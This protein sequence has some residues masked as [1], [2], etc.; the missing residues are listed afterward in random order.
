MED[1]IRFTS[2]ALEN[3]KSVKMLGLS[4]RMSAMIGGLRYAEVAASTVFRK[5]VIGSVVLCMSP[6]RI[7]MLETP[8]ENA[9]KTPLSEQRI[10]LPIWRRWRL[11]RSM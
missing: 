11:S 3:I 8:Q 9:D 6:N 10:H 2:Y 4:P 7:P 5:L 1:R